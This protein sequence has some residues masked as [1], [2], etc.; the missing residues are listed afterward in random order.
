MENFENKN[1]IFDIEKS[2]NFEGNDSVLLYERLQHPGVKKQILDL[3]SEFEQTKEPV[4]ITSYDVDEVGN[5]IETSSSEEERKIK[6][7]EE[8]EKELDERVKAVFHSTDIEHDEVVVGSFSKGKGD[9]GTIF[10]RG[11]N[12]DDGKKYSIKQLSIIEA[13][14]KGHGIRDFMGAGEIFKSKIRSGFDFSKLSIEEKMRKEFI[15]IEMQE[16]FNT[17]EKREID[18]DSVNKRILDYF[19]QPNEIIERMSQLRN[20]FGMKGIE[21]FTREHLQYAKNNYT[22]DTGMGMQIQLFFDAITP[23][24]EE[25]FLELINTLGI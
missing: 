7:R 25:K 15:E 22:K 17:T 11:I 3:M 24:T 2:S 13:H 19:M 18:E 14:E 1:I 9:V 4:R 20:Y 8:L 16:A 5:F 10:L 21:V 12:P 23:E 6:N